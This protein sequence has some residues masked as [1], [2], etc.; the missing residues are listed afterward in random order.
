MTVNWGLGY[1]ATITVFSL[2]W[3]LKPAT[4]PPSLLPFDYAVTALQIMNICGSGTA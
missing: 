2:V 1:E 4:L 3:N